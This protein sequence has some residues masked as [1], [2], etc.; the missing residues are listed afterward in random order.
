MFEPLYDNANITV[1]GGVAYCAIL[2]FQRAG[3]LSF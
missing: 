2:E 3:R 1:C